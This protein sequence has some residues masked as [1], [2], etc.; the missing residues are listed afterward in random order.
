MMEIK[1]GEEEA[2]LGGQDGDRLEEGGPAGLALL[3]ENT[4]LEYHVCLWV[5]HI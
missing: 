1:L 2:G 4:S 3:W 5:G